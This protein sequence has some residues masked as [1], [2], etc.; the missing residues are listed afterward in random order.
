MRRTLAVSLFALVCSTTV[1]AQTVVG[2]GAITGIVLDKYGDGI[3]ETTINL[4][5]KTL[6]V[7]RTML[8]SDDGIFTIPALL[9]G[10]AYDLKVTRRGYAEW[11]LASFDLV[12][13]ETLN[14]RI[15]LYADRPSTAAEAQRSLA[16]VQDSKTSVTATVTPEQ[17]SSL[18]T[19]AQQVDPLLLLAPAVVQ[20]PQGVLVYRGEPA[21]NVFQLDSL[22]VTNNYSRFAPNVAPFI[23]QESVS[24]VQAISAAPTQDFT[25]TY[26]G[27]ANAVSKSGTNSLHASAYDYYAQNA[28]NKPDFFGNGFVPTGRYNN[29]GISLGTPIVNDTLFFFGNIQ[30]LN[31]SSQE[32]NRILN[33]LLTVPDGSA[34]LTTGCTATASQCLQA[35]T[36]IN[37]Q[38]NVKVPETE[39]STT[40]FARMDF[41][42]SDKN[43]FTLSGA[44]LTGR[45]VN[46]LNNATVSTNGGLLGANANVTN[47]T[48][49]AAFGWTHV[50][51][52]S[53]VN[54]FHGGWFRDTMTAAS[55]TTQFPASSSNCLACGT[56]P[57][58]INVAGTSLGNNPAVPFNLREGRYQAADDFSFTLAS[59]TVRIGVDAWRRNDTMD[60]LYARFGQYNYDSL[61][62]F[63]TDFSADVRALKNY[64]TFDQTFGN[65][66]VDTT[67]WFISVFAEDT[68][69][70]KPGLTVNAGVRWDKAHLPKPT[71][72]SSNYLTGFIP[73]PNTDVQPRLGLAYMLDNRTVFRFG[74]GTY[75]DPFPGQL[76]RDLYAGGGNFQTGFTLTPPET[77]TVTFPGVLPSSAVNTLNSTL[78]NQYFAAVRFRNPYSIQGNA[79]I[80]R[81]LNRWVSLAISYIQSTSK[82]LWTTTDINIPGAPLVNETYTVN[83]AQGAAV[84]TYVTPV[85]YSAQAAHRYQFDNEGGSRYR[86]GVAQVRTAPLFGLSVQAS[87][88]WSHSFDDMSGPQVPNTIVQ[89]TYFPSS[90]VGD[91]GPS[92]FDQRNH[93]VV[94]FMWQPVVHKTDALSRYLLNGWLV[95]GIGTYSSSMYVTPTIA[96]MGQQFIVNNTALS[97]TKITMDYTDSL[98]GSGGWS[99]VPWEN[100]NILP[101]GSQFNIDARVSKT[102]PFTAR[103]H[104]TFALDAFNATNHRNISA[105]QTLAYTSTLGVITPVPGVGTPT[106]SYGY[107]FGATARHVEVSFHLLW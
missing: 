68:W 105:V 27:W 92:S 20:S 101:L 104:G 24:E 46:N 89:K 16:P 14:F 106:A 88:T 3:P 78:I 10:A 65:S 47:S 2:S 57:L 5:N 75:Y 91:E 11:E 29:G 63:A 42:A 36:Y 61:S 66:V 38:L 19:P 96:V 64:A 98:N 53:M 6:G 95:S 15:H 71:E 107:P 56:G 83:N 37:Q 41:R 43:T 60:Q 97:N 30:H 48:R 52:E 26:G 84:S 85:W 18:P 1:Y 72:P 12:V 94:N 79:A 100:V 62:A 34:A 76:L 77:G 17:L 45:G 31:N 40:G 7:K 49:Y 67:D 81:R 51:G 74:G 25:Y 103:L 50:I 54:N 82:R 87:Y 86:A 22:S 58:A 102:V 23:M 32:L 21:R 93:A 59:H 69:K 80:E 9:P 73:S 39:N 4:T 44:V 35:Q 70:V 13:G 8:T 90:Y 99:R 28:W 33:P 55:N